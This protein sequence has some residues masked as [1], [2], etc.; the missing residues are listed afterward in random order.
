MTMDEEDVSD[1]SDCEILDLDALARARSQCATPHALGGSSSALVGSSG[2]SPSPTSFFAAF[3]PKKDGD[4]VPTMILYRSPSPVQFERRGND[5]NIVSFDGGHHHDMSVAIYSQPQRRPFLRETLFPPFTLRTPEQENC[6]TPQH[7]VLIMTF[8]II[9]IIIIIIMTI[10][11]IIIMFIS[12]IF[13]MI[14]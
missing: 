5:M 12:I 9:I 11:I 7:V 3:M 14:G 10:I 8:I 2:R 4:S 1:Q 6:S 13:I